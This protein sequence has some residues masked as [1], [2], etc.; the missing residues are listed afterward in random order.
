MNQSLSE[1]RSVGDIVGD[2]VRTCRDQ[3]PKLVK[4]LLAPTIV[5][6]VGKFVLV[7]GVSNEL[8][9]LSS[10]PHILF[11]LFLIL[12]GTVVVLI[13]DLYLTLRQLSL[14]RVINGFAN[15]YEE[16][17]LFLKKR[18]W[19]VILLFFLFYLALIVLIA[20]WTTLIFLV[21]FL[22]GISKQALPAAIAVGAICF[23]M[24]GIIVCTGLIGVPLCII[25]PSVACEE[26]PIFSLIGWGLTLWSKN[27]WRTVFFAA[28]LT[29]CV[30]ALSMALCLP[31]NVLYFFEYARASIAS[32]HTPTNADISIYAQV[33]SSSWHSL[34]NMFLSPIIF[35][36]NGFF[37]LDLRAR[38]EGLDLTRTIET[39][40]AGIVR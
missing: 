25:I 5:E 19:Q 7:W 39:V 20:F 26:R 30:A 4:I 17:Y 18:R 12:V 34:V 38:R 24:V 33:L 29:V 15:S 40:E 21:G 22:M 36:A 23:C 31:A 16:A 10:L 32:G 37:Y 1:F 35:I 13:A 9:R 8:T 6:I 11:G 28:L 3:I 27:F 2:S 14:V